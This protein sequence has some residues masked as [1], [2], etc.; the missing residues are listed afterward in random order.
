VASTN[1][2]QTKYSIIADDIRNKIIDG[3]YIPGERI[4]SEARLAKIYNTTPVTAAKAVNILSDEGLLV[5]RRGSGTYVTDQRYQPVISN[6][7]ITIGILWHSPFMPHML[8][9]SFPGNITRGSIECWG[10]QGAQVEHD[11]NDSSEYTRGIWNASYR[12][13]TVECIGEK[14]NSGQR[15]PDLAVI[16]ERNFDGIMT[17]SIA[18]QDWLEKLLELNIPTVIIDFPLEKFTDKA[19]IVYVDPMSGYRQ[20]VTAFVKTGLKRIH[21]IHAL[22]GGATP[23]PDMPHEERVAFIMSH[24]RFDLDSPFRMNAYRIGMAD[25]NLSVKETWIH[26]TDFTQTSTRKLA[27]ELADLPDSERPE[28]VVCHS[29]AHAEACYHVFSEKGLPLKAAGAVD[30]EYKGPCYPI[31]IDGVS[32]GAAGAALL[33]SRLQQKDRPMLRV[34]M[35]MKFIGKKE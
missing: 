12:G 13:M 29:M 34:G 26:A 21:F 27:E 31:H 2:V 14:A 28:A 10:I 4:P 9:D 19:D 35:P 5:R 16:K 17:L 1:S 23:S 20:A 30:Q 24:L 25:N 15:H 18:E 33:T 8:S 32:V 3:H 22:V 7:H 11:V 6:K